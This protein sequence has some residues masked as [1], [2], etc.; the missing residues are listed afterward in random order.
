MN[1][2]FFILTLISGLFYLPTS[3]MFKNELALAN[4]LISKRCKKHTLVAKKDKKLSRTLFSTRTE[5]NK[6]KTSEDLKPILITSLGLCAATSG[7]FCVD[8]GINTTL[9][10]HHLILHAKH[11]FD[12][13]LYCSPNNGLALDLAGV[14]SSA[15]C[16]ATFAAGSALCVKALNDVTQ[17]VATEVEKII[18]KETIS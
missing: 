9:F 8:F 16:T 2:Q 18:K 13:S 3:A 15:L 12:P 6:K 11:A 7:L 17:P 10:I 1:K 4:H 14:T 5:Q